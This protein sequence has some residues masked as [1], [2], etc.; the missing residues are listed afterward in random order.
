MNGV[1]EVGLRVSGGTRIKHQV[2]NV[3]RRAEQCQ[4]TQM[5]FDTK[6]EIKCEKLPGCL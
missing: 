6:G 5:I 3:K 2:V 4:N 1:S